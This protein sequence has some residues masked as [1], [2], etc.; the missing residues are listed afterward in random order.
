VVATVLVRL[1]HFTLTLFILLLTMD[2]RQQLEAL[3]AVIAQLQSEVQSLRNNSAQLSSEIQF[4][5]SNSTPTRPKPALPDPKKFNGQSYRFD[6]WLP[7]IRAKLRVDGAAIGDTVAQFYYVFL[8][9]ESVVQAMVLPQL[10]QAEESETWDYNTILGQLS[11]VYDNPNKVQEAEDKLLSLRQGTDSIPVYI[12]KFERVLYEARGQDWPDIN[13]ISIF[14]NGL[15]STIRNRLSQQLA[16]P[17]RYPDFI[18]VIQQLSGRSSSV[19]PSNVPSSNAIPQIHS[20]HHNNDAMDLNVLQLNS[21]DLAPTPKSILKAPRARSTSPE[22]RQEYR[23]KGCCTRCGSDEHWVQNCFFRPHSPKAGQRVAINTIDKVKQE[24]E[25][26]EEYD[27]WEEE[28]IPQ[29]INEVYWKRFG[30]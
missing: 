4:L 15:S 30:K 23:R 1:P 21:I 26:E 2:P 29:D 5:R 10:T 22:L 19:T 7:S 25:Q 28:D 18:R 20:K 13:K 27:G 14:R 24:Q 17:S 9:L 12:S 11:R 6:T 8:N 3:Q 16:L